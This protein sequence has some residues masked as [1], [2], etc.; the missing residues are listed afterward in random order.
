MPPER[1]S[2]RRAAIGDGPAFDEKKTVEI[3][4]SLAG[5][6][7]EPSGGLVLSVGIYSSGRKLPGSPQRGYNLSLEVPCL[8]N[9]FFNVIRRVWGK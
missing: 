7:I 2:R 4:L 5:R 8:V 6:E 3:V 1:R 9:C